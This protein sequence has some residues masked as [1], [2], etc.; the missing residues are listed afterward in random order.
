MQLA[1]QSIQVIAHLSGERARLVV[2]SG[3]LRG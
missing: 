2:I 1:L 3:S